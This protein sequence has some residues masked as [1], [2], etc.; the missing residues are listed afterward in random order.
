VP[1]IWQGTAGVDN[2]DETCSLSCTL[3]HAIPHKYCLYKHT[4]LPDMLFIH[5]SMCFI[6][7]FLI[8]SPVSLQG[9]A[10]VDDEDETGLTPLHT[11][12]ELGA[13][14]LAELLLEKGADLNHAGVSFITF[15]MYFL[16]LYLFSLLISICLY[17]TYYI[18]YLLITYY[19][20]L[21]TYINI[22]IHIYIDISKE[23]IY[24]YMFVC[25]F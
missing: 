7:C 23:Y 19:L 12:A 13:A 9:A 2:E 14:S 21:F 22:Y 18:Y 24:T 15:L 25:C 11:A 1:C 10:G 6:A 3:P 20:L 5:C 16:Y 17:I 4:V 8:F